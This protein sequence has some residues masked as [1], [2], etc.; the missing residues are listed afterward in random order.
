MFKY[1]ILQGEDDY[2]MCLWTLIK[3]M[4]NFEPPHNQRGDNTAHPQM[5]RTSPQLSETITMG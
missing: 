1:F 2:R 3:E 5:S 4:E